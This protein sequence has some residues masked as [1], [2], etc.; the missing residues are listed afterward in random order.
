ME[1]G[2]YSCCFKIG[3]IIHRS[4]ESLVQDKAKNLI[5]TYE[6]TKNESLTKK[7]SPDAMVF[8]AALKRGTLITK[9]DD[10][11]YAVTY[12]NRK[13]RLRMCTSIESIHFYFHEEGTENPMIHLYYPLDY[14]VE[15]SCEEVIQALQQKP[16][17]P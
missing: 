10:S 2:E 15:P 14:G 17:K 3:N 9:V 1:Q 6:L 12:R 7:L 13:A 4:S 5:N 16:S 8:G 11:N